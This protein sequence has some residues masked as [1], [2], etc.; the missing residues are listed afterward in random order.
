MD[1][2]NRMK[3][4]AFARV[5]RI[6]FRLIDIQPAALQVTDPNEDR[7]QLAKKRADELLARIQAGEDF[8]ELAKQ[9]S[10]G[11][12]REYGGLWKPVNPASLAAPYDALAAE[13]ERM[14]AGQVSRPIAVEG[15]IFIMKLEEKQSAGYELFEQVQGQVE[16]Q[17]IFE[18]QKEVFDRLNAKIIRQAE[19]GRTDKFIDFCLEKIYQMSNQKS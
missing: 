2:Y 15:H 13:A 16:E 7:Q 17:L 10:H 6:T 8:G 12:W 14:E 5:A 11:L 19:L 9:Y 3:D 1:C 4:K 18:R